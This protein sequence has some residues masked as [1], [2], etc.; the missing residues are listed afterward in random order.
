MYD[1]LGD[2]A[3]AVTL[4]RIGTRAYRLAYDAWLDAKIKINLG[5]NLA[6]IGEDAEAKQVFESA[7]ALCND[8]HFWDYAAESHLQAG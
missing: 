2:H 3:S 8:G 7:L 5:V 4:H 6:R 1:A